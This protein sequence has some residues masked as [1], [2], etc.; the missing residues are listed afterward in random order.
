MTLTWQ[1]L[2]MTKT[3]AKKIT[4]EVRR[5]EGE[6]S[7]A[8]QLSH[9]ISSYLAGSQTQG[10]SDTEGSSDTLTAVRHYVNFT[11]KQFLFNSIL[12]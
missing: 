12:K 6:T 4:M 10:L 3:T 2:W 5:M 7:R 11:Q 9:S 8:E 1:M